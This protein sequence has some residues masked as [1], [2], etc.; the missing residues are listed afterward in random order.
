MLSYARMGMNIHKDELIF[1]KVKT[2]NQFS[3][4]FL[5]HG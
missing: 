3:S 4:S 5:I 1:E 2:E